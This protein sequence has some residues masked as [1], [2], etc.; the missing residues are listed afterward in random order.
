MF[1]SN[2]PELKDKLIDSLRNKKIFIIFWIDNSKQTKK[3]LGTLDSCI[4]MKELKMKNEKIMMIHDEGDVITKHNDVENAT[5]KQPVSHA[6]MIEL[7]EFLREHLVLKRIFVSATI[8]N[9][10]SLYKINSYYVFQLKIDPK[11]RG[12]KHIKFKPIEDHVSDYKQ[13]LTEEISRGG[14]IIC[15]TERKLKDHSKNLKSLSLDF[16]NILIHT[17]N[18]KN[19]EIH[20][21]NEKFKELLMKLKNKKG[22]EACS[23][24]GNFLYLSNDIPLCRFYGIAQEAG[25]KTII[26]I[27]NN[28]IDRGISFV[29]DTK[30]DPLTA[31]TMI[32]KTGNKM[33]AVGITQIIG[34]VTGISAPNLERRVYTSRENIELVK[35][36]NRN[37]EGI[38]EISEDGKLTSEIYNNEFIFE[39]L[40]GRP[41]DRPSTGVNYP[42]TRLSDNNYVTE[43]LEFDTMKEGLDYIKNNIDN[44]T[45]PNI[46]TIELHKEGKFYKANPRVNDYKVYS[47]SELDKITNWKWKGQ[48]R[49][50]LFLPCY[51]DISNPET[52]VWRVLIKP[53]QFR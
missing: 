14:I 3:I 53:L 30:K 32:L 50:Y 45:G 18:G 27:G 31:I 47:S 8:D 35:T 41:V 40:N 12:L 2:T 42:S 22:K 4:I 6:V 5:N 38:L 52:V 36:H 1:K 16:P 10:Y 26:T 21:T 17:Y 24:K 39:D 25:E 33:H 13:I 20:T 9:I 28:K 29:A 43:T 37:R 44:S 34:R 7:T 15:C 51:K 46:A 49:N 23:R 48:N 19:M 11:Y